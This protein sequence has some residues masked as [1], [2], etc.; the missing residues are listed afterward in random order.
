MLANRNFSNA[1][2]SD[3]DPDPDSD[4]GVFGAPDPDPL[5]RGIDP[6]P[7]QNVT[8]RQ[9]WPNGISVK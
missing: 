6:D 7:L 3:G 8:N 1:R 4:P 9:D 2:S 5:V